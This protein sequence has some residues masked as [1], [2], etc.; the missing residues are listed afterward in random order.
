MNNLKS[1]SLLDLIHLSQDQFAALCGPLNQHMQYLETHF[2]VSIRY[3]KQCLHIQGD[4]ANVERAIAEIEQLSQKLTL[5]NDFGIN[6]IKQHT[7]AKSSKQHFPP[8]CGQSFSIKPKSTAQ[9]TYIAN[10]LQY[11]INFAVGP[12]GTGKTFLAVACALQALEQNLVEKI[13]LTRP[14]VEAG[15]KLGFLPGDIN[16]K[17]DPYLKPLYDSLHT[18]IGAPQTQKMM[19]KGL[20]EITP[21]AYMRGRTLS[22]AFIIMDESQNA[23]QEQMKMMLTR[24]GEHTRLVIAGDPTQIDLPKK[25]ASGLIPA[26][27]LLSS[28]RGIKINRFTANDCVRHPLVKRI[29]KAYE[30]L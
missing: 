1:T 19:E 27:T 16:Q 25:G 6:D 5:Q 30:N 12:A 2:S 8:F 13:T 11:D 17:V 18:L 15:E 7:A 26:V 4:A 9:A 21:L 22:H 23:T 10:I 14:I 24:L 28:I 3:R 20:I 29:I